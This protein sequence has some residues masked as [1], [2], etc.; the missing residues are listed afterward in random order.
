MSMEF[1]IKRKKGVSESSIKIKARSHSTL[2]IVLLILAFI[3]QTKTFAWKQDCPISS[4][5]QML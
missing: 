2:L 5:L 1:L 3:Y 4:D